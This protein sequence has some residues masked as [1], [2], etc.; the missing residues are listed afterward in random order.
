MTRSSYLRTTSFIILIISINLFA[1]QYGRNRIQYESKDWQFIQSEHFDVY[2]YQGGRELTEF[3]ACTAES[4]Y[5]KLSKHFDYSLIA[6]IPFVV[7]RSHNDFSETNISYQVV[8][9]SVGGFTEFL[10][11]RV[12]IPFEGSYE[13]FRHVIHHE[14]THAVMLQMLYGAGPGAIINGV[15][16]MQPP[17]WFNEGLAEF[18]SLGWDTESDMYVRD[19]TLRGYLPPIQYLQAFM[20]YKGGQ[21]VLL[22]L[23]DTYGPHKLGEL[24]QRMR[25]TRSFEK[26][27]Q[28]AL[29]ESLD[30][31]SK[32]WQRYMR[33]KYWPEIAN[34]KE[35]SDY[36][37]AITDH[38][39]WQNF[40]NNSPALSPTGDRIAFLSDRSGY[41]DI[42]L[43]SVTKPEKITRLVAGQRK[44]D[45]EE[46]HWLRP[47]M[48]WS[49]DGKYIAFASRAGKED[50]L[51][52]IDVDK[53]KI[54]HAFKF[55]LD[56]LF[57]PA[58]S[59]V[60]NEIAF[61]GLKHQQSDI[62]V[63][64]LDTHKLRNVTDDIFSDLEPSWSPDGR[65]IVFVSDRKENVEPREMR[66]SINMVDFDYRTTDIFQIH[67]N[68]A[69]LQRLTTSP[70]NERSPQWSADGK[71]LLYVSDQS[72]I[73]NIYYYNPD[74]R[75]EKAL[76][77]LITG[78]A[79]LSWGLQSDRLAFTAFSNGGYD[80]YVWANPFGFEKEPEQPQKTKFMVELEHGRR[81]PDIPLSK[82]EE[83]Q[84]V[85]QIQ[86]ERDFSH[87]VFDSKFK[88]GI[89]EPTLADTANIELPPEEYR[90]PG[91][92][93]KVRNYKTK[94][95][96]DHVGMN[97]GYDPIL[98]LQG[99][100]EIYASDV[101]GDHQLVFGL[102][103]V[104]DFTNSNFKFAY[105]NQ[106]YR[107]NWSVSAYQFVYF[108]ATTFGIVRF[109][110]R[111]A[112]WDGSY[113]LTRF[114]RFDF[115]LRFINNAMDNLDFPMFPGYSLNL[116]MPSI[117]YT[118]DNS[119]PGYTAPRAG[120]R[121]YIGING[122]PRIGTDGRQFVTTDFDLRQ[123]FSLSRD[124]S[125]AFRLA[126]GASFGADPTVF[127]LGGMD[128][129]V[130]YRYHQNI[131]IGSI[132]DYFLA[133][134]LTPLRGAD[135]Y[136]MVGNRAFLFN[137]EFR[138][139]LIQY[140][141]MRFPLPIAFQN[142]RGVFFWDAGSAWQQGESW[143]FVDTNADNK[144]YVRDVINGFGYGVRVNLGFFLLRFD[145]AWRTDFD[146]ISAPRYYFSIGGDF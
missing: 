132:S 70:Q 146:K 89:I 143:K 103:F 84:V 49:P 106:K 17:L 65:D 123:Y 11:D 56:G 82:S 110:N 72:G 88:E 36:A 97:A 23:E 30:E 40:V 34:R 59:P 102:D 69:G 108:Y 90:E 18:E 22:Y 12:I 138:F 1:Q 124:Y 44:A 24:L 79:Q 117:S 16:K 64:D 38:T 134:L 60:S 28:Q 33:Q 115:G 85:S 139:P 104:Q 107:L 19:A 87:Y 127:I 141:V 5:V 83:E 27:W 47:G 32:K 121:Y 57:S 66:E 76:T 136:E 135:L 14:L 62:Y 51:N 63:Y 133:N 39:K 43:T 58:W 126:G 81:I 41:F 99:L 113:P 74:T 137:A 31:T 26:A 86:K 2:F 73:S 144:R 53:K 109:A 98:G 67:K 120:Q 13:K 4:A 7:Y 75:E 112:G 130:N 100:T 119:I 78:C 21:S 122:S 54:I 118:K 111:G 29:N 142:I 68:G 101:L 131:D 9:E 25:H 140:F 37:Q 45:L 15:A 77:N 55:G 145:A 20:A 114:D 116:L 105:L 10:K 48:S 128:N 71:Y 129:W 96:I 125:F 95:S 92:D 46:L 93:F 94:F 80:V 3:V 42:Y 52:I 8:E 61:V 6:R 91:G 50:A 35:P